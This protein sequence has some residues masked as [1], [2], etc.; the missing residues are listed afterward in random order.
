MS[1]GNPP[2][3]SRKSD[4][5]QTIDLEAERITPPADE[6]ATADASAEPATTTE[7][8]AET[9]ATTE[10]STEPAAEPAPQAK[11][12][13]EAAPV[14]AKRGGGG[15]SGALAAGIVGGLIVLVGAG[16]AQYA[17][18]IPNLG[19]V[20]KIQLPDYAGQIASLQQKLA[21]V[22]KKAANPPVT[23]LAPVED[24]LKNIETAMSKLPV[25][26]LTDVLA[27]K[28]KLDETAGK[29][30]KV[31][32]QM[33]SVANRLQQTE[34]KVN[35]PRDD[36]DVARAIASAGLKAA[37]DR[38]G[39]F[40][41]ELQTLASVAPNDQSVA[42][43]QAFAAKGVPS[44][45]D[46]IK[47]Y[48]DAADQMLALL[49]KPVA[50][51]SLSDRLFKSAFSVI[52]VRPVGNVEGSSP[53]AII[54]RIGDKLQGSDLAGALKEWDTLPDNLKAAG[55]DYHAALEARVKVEALV[56]QTLE[57]AVKTTGKQG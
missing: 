30:D 41:A 46:L 7:P 20:Q 27:I 37:I 8:S 47:R 25:G 53:E 9:V 51:Q 50:G 44:R 19:P 48:P 2:R 4:E 52:K 34:T 33:A 18:F 35:A 29:M 12:A 32:A 55:Q 40:Q 26:D 43:L 11:A 49:N 6:P 57:H 15:G 39:P 54:A 23:N 24:R 28:G 10:P 21:D 45:A 3:R 1:N 42:A 56:A 14:A 31:E 13:A 38:G 22:E 16:A 17:G 5:P 36:V